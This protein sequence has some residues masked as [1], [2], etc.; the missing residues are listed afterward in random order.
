MFRTF[1]PTLTREA[2]Y[3]EH[4][5]RAPFSEPRTA[6]EATALLTWDLVVELIV[7]RPRPDMIVSRAGKFLQGADPATAGQARALFASG[8]SIVLRCVERFDA[9]LR[10]LADDFGSVI[11][12]EVNV[13]AFATPASSLGFGWHYDCEEVFILQTAGS[14][15]YHLRANTVNPEPTRDAMPRDMQVER[16]TS[17]MLACTLLAGDWLYIP[18]GW[19]HRARGLDD[20]LS[21]SVGVLTPG[22][23]HLSRQ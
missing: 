7:G 10:A 3:R 8:C 16:E 23:R 9:G 12:G 20:S 2:F 13:H 6:R 19:W 22:A 4:F 1:H 15:E 17:P 14:K 5:Q 11:E 18:R 21:I